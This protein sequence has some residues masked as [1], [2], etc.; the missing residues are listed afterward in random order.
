[1]Y[2]VIVQVRVVLKR[3]VVGV[4]SPTTILFIAQNNGSVR[5]DDCVRQFVD[6]SVQVV[7][8]LLSPCSK[9]INK[10]RGKGWAREILGTR[11]MCFSPPGAWVAFFFLA[12]FFH[13]M[14]NGLHVRKRGT[15][16][17][18]VV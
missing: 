17:S 9:T 6:Y 16:R 14:H 8:L 5:E 3:T 11:C 7:L 12:G 15:T 4:L 13:V 2:S 10:P 18:Y 1:M